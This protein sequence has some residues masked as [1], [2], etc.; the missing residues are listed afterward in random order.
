[1][2][3]PFVR[4]DLELFFRGERTLPRSL[5]QLVHSVSILSREI[6]SQDHLGGVHRNARLSRVNDT[7]EDLRFVVRGR[8][9]HTFQI[10]SRQTT[11]AK[12]RQPHLPSLVAEFAGA[13]L[14]T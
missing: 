6:K 14:Q 7:R 2:T 5:R 11:G 4:V 10:M 9:A 12:S 13:V 1:M 3:D 8:G